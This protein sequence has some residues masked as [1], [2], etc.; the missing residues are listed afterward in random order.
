MAT[1]I[2]PAISVNCPGT[3][4]IKEPTSNKARSQRRH[5]RKNQFSSAALNAITPTTAVMMASTRASEEYS[6]ANISIGEYTAKK[7]TRKPATP[8]RVDVHPTLYGLAPAIPA[9]VKAA[10]QTGGVRLDKQAK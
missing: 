2:P 10:R 6:P 9:A 1:D 3:I 8:K 7:G 4:N 5:S